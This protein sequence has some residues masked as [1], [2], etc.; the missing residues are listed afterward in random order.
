MVKIAF[1]T[2]LQQFSTV[3]KHH[4]GHDIEAWESAGLHNSTLYQR[5]WKIQLINIWCCQ[6]RREQQKANILEGTESTGGDT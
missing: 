3:I 1:Y 6:G 4:H 5:R 2:L